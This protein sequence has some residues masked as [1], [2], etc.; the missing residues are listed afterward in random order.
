MTRYD[1]NA[2]A[3]TLEAI[4]GADM[5]TA[6][7]TCG[8]CGRSGVVAEVAVYLDGPGLVARCPSCDH[9]LLVVTQRRGMYCVDR[10]GFAQLSTPSA[11]A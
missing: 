1:G 3:G 6:G 8:G 7:C 9:V 4:F 5:T 2:I 10:A 11:L